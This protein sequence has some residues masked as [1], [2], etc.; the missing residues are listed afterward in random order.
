MSTVNE[1]LNRSLSIMQ[2]LNLTRL[3]ITCVFDQAIYCKALEI[4]SKNV[5][6]YK[7]VLRLGT[8]HTLRTLPLSIIRKRFQ[9][10]GLKNLCIDSGIV[11]EGSVSALLEG[12]SYNRA[13]RVH[14]LAYET[15][16]RK[17]W[18][19]FQPWVGK[20]G[21]LDMDQI[22][23]ALDKFA[24]LGNDLSKDNHDRVI[25]SQPFKCLNERFQEFVDHL[26]KT[27]GPL[28]A[29]CMSYIDMVANAA[30]GKSGRP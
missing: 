25:Q 19:G 26:R 27:N 8:F 29:F 6:T 16:M 30:H 17:A 2:S 13:I 21:P 1:I 12:R 5:D 11:T 14:K 23:R 22:R 7:P 18:R 24:N 28:A 9:D 10:A 4:K 15:L 20:R 3:S